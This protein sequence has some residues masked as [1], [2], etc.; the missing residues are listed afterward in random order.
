MTL[1]ETDFLSLR[2]LQ[3]SVMDF[4]AVL[5]IA[6]NRIAMEIVAYRDLQEVH[7]IFSETVAEF[8]SSPD[9]VNRLRK[10]LDTEPFCASLQTALDDPDG[11]YQEEAALMRLTTE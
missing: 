7:H 11:K 4:Y 5:Q 3:C 1:P 10:I 8:L 2:D 9:C 6:L